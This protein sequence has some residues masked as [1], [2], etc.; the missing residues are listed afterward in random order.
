MICSN[1][2]L[3]ETKGKLPALGWNSWNA[4]FCDI[5]STKVMTA[6]NQVV[7]LGLKDAGYEYINSEFY[8]EKQF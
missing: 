6:A 5:N 3:T 2:K 7:S 1:E 8:L 4:F